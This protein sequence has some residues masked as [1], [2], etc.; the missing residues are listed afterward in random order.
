MDAGVETLRYRRSELLLEIFRTFVRHSVAWFSNRQVKA[1]RRQLVAFTHDYIGTELDLSGVYEE[2]HLRLIFSWITKS[3]PD[4]LL[5]NAVDVGANIGNHSLF[6]SDFFPRVFSFEITPRTFRVLQLNSELVPNVTCF[7]IGLSNAEGDVYLAENQRNMGGTR[8][9]AGPAEATRSVRVAPLDTFLEEIAPVSLMKVDV[10]GHE[11][12]VLQGAERTIKEHTP[13]VIFEQH[14]HDF[15]D[16]SSPCIDLLRAYGYR[17]FFAIEEVSKPAVEVR[18]VRT[19]MI[20]SLWRAITGHAIC[21]KARSTFV[22]AQ[23]NMIL[24]VP[25]SS[26][27]SGSGEHRSTHGD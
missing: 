11:L 14:R 3:A 7:N 24:A 27:A 19:D 4:V 6:F 17:T 20:A 9:V 15:V 10:E 18:G 16:G 22:P 8:I 26:E 2:D 12:R 13:L 21:L 23:Y 1:S 5:G 25:P